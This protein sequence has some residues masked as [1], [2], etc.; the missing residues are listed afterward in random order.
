[1]VSSEG[2]QVQVGRPSQACGGPGDCDGAASS[3]DGVRDRGRLMAGNGRASSR[4]VGAPVAVA[5]ADAPLRHQRCRG[6]G[7]TGG[8]VCYRRPQR[9]VPASGQSS[10]GCDFGRRPPQS[11]SVDLAKPDGSHAKTDAGP[12]R[13]ENEA[14]N[15]GGP[16]KREHAGPPACLA[17]GMK[18]APQALAM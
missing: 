7:G 15:E 18:W 3:G 5:R 13:N 2:R 16:T 12:A 4:Q 6:S 8:A 11:P 10:Q 9:H 14:P 17:L 1:L